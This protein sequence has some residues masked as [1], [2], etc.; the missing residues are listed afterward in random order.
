MVGILYIFLIYEIFLC[1]KGKMI[2][3]DHK[4]Y[5]TSKKQASER[6]RACAAQMTAKN[7]SGSAMRSIPAI[8]SVSGRTSKPNSSRR[9]TQMRILG[10]RWTIS[11]MH[12]LILL[13][14]I[15]AL[16]DFGILYKL[17][18]SK[19]NKEFQYRFV[20]GIRSNDST[21]L[22][23]VFRLVKILLKCKETNPGA[24]KIADMS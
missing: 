6:P 4:K 14:A 20:G 15:S 16:P 23:L 5:Q 9:F 2:E 21:Y 13:K 8:G 10:R 3:N 17:Y 24:Y 1:V 12:R 19:W 18:S 22:I 11:V 7:L